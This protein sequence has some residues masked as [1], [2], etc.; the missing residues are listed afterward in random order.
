MFSARSK[1]SASCFARLCP[2]TAEKSTFLSCAELN[3]VMY[4]NGKMSSP[5]TI[6]GTSMRKTSAKAT[7]P[8]NIAERMRT[9]TGE[10]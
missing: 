8:I 10:P 1:R 9:M 3:I 2:V 4:I 6:C 7:G 5:R